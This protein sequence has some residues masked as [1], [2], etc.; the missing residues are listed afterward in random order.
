MR[1]EIERLT[2]ENKRLLNQLRHIREEQALRKA[3]GRSPQTSIVPSTKSFL[4]QTTTSLEHS[5]FRFRVPITDSL[6]PTE[7]DPLSSRVPKVLPLE[8]TGFR[9]PDATDRKRIKLDR[10]MRMTA[11]VDLEFKRKVWS[12]EFVITQPQTQKIPVRLTPEN[13]ANLTRQIQLEEPFV[14]CGVGV[15]IIDAAQAHL[16]LRQRLMGDET[17]TDS[18]I[19]GRS[20]TPRPQEIE[21]DHDLGLGCFENEFFYDCCLLFLF[22]I[23]VILDWIWSTCSCWGVLSG[24]LSYGCC[25]N[26]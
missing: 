9:F 11:L 4:G 13:A 18:Y 19:E 6:T 12:V 20:S 10:T 16:F 21:S 7:S 23:S 24:I 1:A 3:S 25:E 15:G 8:K 22:H 17:V 26:C 14:G 2:H 5:Q